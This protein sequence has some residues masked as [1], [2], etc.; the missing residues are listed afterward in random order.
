MRRLRILSMLLALL[1]LSAGLSADGTENAVNPEHPYDAYMS[2]LFTDQGISA[3]T[4]PRFGDTA[5]PI[6]PS[7][8]KWNLYIPDTLQPKSSVYMILIPD[9]MTASD[10]TESDTGKAWMEAADSSTDPFAVAFIEPENGETWN[11]SESPERRDD[12]ALGYAVYSAIRDKATTVNAF[13]SVDKNCVYLVGY[14]EGAV[15]ASL[16]AAAWPQNFASTTLIAPDSFEEKSIEKWLDTPIFPYSPDNLNGYD[17]SITGESVAMPMHIFPGSNVTAA[18]AIQ[19]RWERINIGCTNP[20][21]SRDRAYEVSELIAEHMPSSIV[22][23]TDDSGRFMGYPGG[24]IKSIYRS[25]DD[26]NMDRNTGRF[27]PVWE[28]EYIDDYIRRWALYI[29]ESYDGTE[30]VPLV[31]SLHGSSASFVDHAEE[32]RWP[33]LADKYGFIVAFIQAYPSGEP[34]PFPQ[35]FSL[36]GKAQ[37]DVDYIAKVVEKISAMLS[38]DESRM[39]LTG[40]SMGSRMSQLFALSD[41]GSLFAAYGPVSSLSDAETLSSYA[42]YVN[43]ASS[44][45]TTLP[46]WFFRGEFDQTGYAID[47]TEPGDTKAFDF[48]GKTVNGIAERDSEPV[49][50]NLNP[51]MRKYIT[52]SYSIGDAPV[53]RYTQIKQSPH[54]YMSEEAVLLWSWFS[55]WSRDTDGTSRYDGNIIEISK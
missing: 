20:D 54:V 24:T 49:V 27:I 36:E 30:D 35:W 2:G 8:W 34:N 26:S 13:L 43:D 14:E 40:H 6:R 1:M 55:R 50:E 39:Y 17:S 19:E 3:D 42:D 48:Y 5:Y 22:D 45:E 23:L 41:K 32:T 21:T 18:K 15:M 4:T 7:S 25:Y 38:I 11:I 31:V 53:V 29:P 28:D 47:G 51:G 16:I 52:T 9:G 12:I 10:F 44:N 37:Q 46:M 33:D